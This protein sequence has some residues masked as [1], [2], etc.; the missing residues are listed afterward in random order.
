[1]KHFK[2]VL[3]DFDGTLVRSMK[4][5]FR[6][7]RFVMANHGIKI[8]PEDYYPFEGL[9]G[10]EVAEHF[11]KR[12]GSNQA[13][14][15]TLAKE[16]E[17]RYLKGHRLKLYPGVNSLL[18]A[19]RKNGVP[20]AI[21]TAG[22]KERVQRSLPEGFLGAFDAMVTGEKT[23]RGKP[24][25]DPYLAGAKMLGFKPS[26]CIVVENAPLGIESAK[27]AGCYCVAIASTLDENYLRKADEIVGRF[28]DLKS[29]SVVKALLKRK[30]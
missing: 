18:R 8:R 21:V 20:A 26:Q 10:P 19:L 7:W 6:A 12:Y 4:D 24:F 16:K 30:P 13:D 5:L 17:V 15:E 25:P 29:L 9:R 2:A 28:S 1:M 11:L 22:F 23:K 14:P 27:R 3:F